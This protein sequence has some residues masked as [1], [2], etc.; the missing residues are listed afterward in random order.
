V[1]YP[2]P[3]VN[4]ITLGKIVEK[5]KLHFKVRQNPKNRPA[6]FAAVQQVIL[7]LSQ[8]GQIAEIPT[9]MKQKAHT[10]IPEKYYVSDPSCPYRLAV[11]FDQNPF[12]AD[13][14]SHG[15]AVY[16][17]NLLKKGNKK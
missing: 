6:A 11:G 15:C 3:P 17:C 1:H 13:T 2:I 12:L 16:S 9:S 8:T 5:L 4:F 14:T 10:K 7:I